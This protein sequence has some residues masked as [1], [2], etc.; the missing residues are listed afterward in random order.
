MA[1]RSGTR[2][3][4]ASRDRQGG[5]GPATGKQKSRRTAVS[6][7][8]RAQRTGFRER[9]AWG[10]AEVSLFP[11]SP[12]EG[13]EFDSPPARSRPA[14]GSDETVRGWFWWGGMVWDGATEEG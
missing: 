14:M 7:E 4:K 1:Q 5:I 8:H 3:T 13:D 9:G 12:T 2:A 6:T 11:I 10:G